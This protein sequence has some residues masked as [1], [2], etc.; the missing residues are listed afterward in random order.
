MKREID[1]NKRY[2][3]P[4]NLAEIDYG[5]CKI[6]ISVD[7]ACWIVFDNEYQYSFY[8]LLKDNTIKDALSQFVGD[9]QDAKSVIIQIEGKDF[10]NT[11]VAGCI[12]PEQQVL[13]IYMTNG[14]NLHC[15]HCY[16]YAGQSYSEELTTTEIK[17]VLHSFKKCGGANITFSGG[18]ISLRNDLME[19]VQYASS[20]NL[21]VRLLTNGTLWKGTIIE[22]ISHYIN[23]IQISVD[24]YDEASNAKIRGKGNFIK[25][26]KTID[27][28]IN[29]GVKTEIAITPFY[30]DE[31]DAHIQD[32]ADF[33]V[34]LSNKYK[35][36][37][38]A[39]KLANQMLEGREIKITPEQQVHYTQ[40]INRIYSLYYQQD[41]TDYSFIAAFSDNKIMNNCMFGELSIAANG[42]VYLCSRVASNTAVA[43]IRTTPFDKIMEMSIVAQDKSNIKNL[44]PCNECDLMY[45]CGGGCR[46]DYFPEFAKCN[47][48]LQLDTDKIKPRKCS[49]LEKELFYQMMIKTNNR[50]LK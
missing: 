24:G 31:L 9:I 38:F 7:T 28:F 46:I 18:E 27:L 6:V 15:P 39:I 14:C 4:K 21:S 13:H 48:I 3:F 37:P 17:S 2:L 20:I 25:S 36:K 34:Q 45:I 8:N 10:T 16:M 50:L 40:V 44:K 35:G 23:S 29:A 49:C 47:D 12:N 5:G 26:L 19:L 41:I 42:D 22:Q 32:Y 43:N 33:I 11:H 30:D 1:I